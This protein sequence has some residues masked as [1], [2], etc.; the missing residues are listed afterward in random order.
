MTKRNLWNGWNNPKTLK[1]CFIGYIALCI[2]SWYREIDLFDHY[3][4][5]MRVEYSYGTTMECNEKWENMS[6]LLRETNQILAMVCT[7]L[8]MAVVSVM[9]VHRESFFDNWEL[10]LRRVPNFRGRYLC[11]KLLLGSIPAACHMVYYISQWLWRYRLYIKEV[12]RQT[13]FFNEKSRTVEYQALELDEF[14]SVVPRKSFLEMLLY[15]VLTTFL[16]VLLNLTVRNIKKDM[17]GFIM[18]I[19]GLLA[20]VILFAEGIVLERPVELAVLSICVAIVVGFNVRHV[21]LKW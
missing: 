20:A 7:V 1:W 14:L 8:F 2:L 16:L 19:T 5:F 9:A 10:T 3:L 17:L 13:K 15:L 6:M 21:Y 18:A 4:F 11:S 12:K